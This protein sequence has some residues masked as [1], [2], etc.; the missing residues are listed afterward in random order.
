[1]R[2]GSRGRGW[3]VWGLVGAG[4]ADIAANRRGAESGRLPDGVGSGV[5]RP[6]AQTAGDAQRVRVME[7]RTAWA[8]SEDSH[9]TPVFKTGDQWNGGEAETSVRTELGDGF[10][11]A[12][13]TLGLRIEARERYLLAR[14]KAAFDESGASLT[15]RVDPG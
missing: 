11:Y 4:I 15:L 8:M 12:H 5:R 10:A 7:D 2:T 13:T 3:E 14:Q 9:L 1:M 6:V